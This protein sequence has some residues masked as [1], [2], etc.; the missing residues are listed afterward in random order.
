MTFAALVLGAVLNPGGILAW[1]V[2]GLIAGFL[3]SAVMRGGYGFIGDIIVGIVG[4]FIG[5]LVMDLLAPNATYGFWG[6]LV[7]AFIGACVL[8]AILRAFS[9]GF[10]RRT[11]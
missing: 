10:T 5:G 8:I 11:P 6:S 1:L 2:V 3:A 4:A 9:G 7:V